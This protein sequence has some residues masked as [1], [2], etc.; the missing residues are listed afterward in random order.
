[1]TVKQGPQDCGCTRIAVRVSLTAVGWIIT[2]VAAALSVGDN[3]WRRNTELP[4][5][6]ERVSRRAPDLFPMNR[7]LA[8]RGVILV[9]VLWIVMILSVAS[10]SL[11]TA[12]RTQLS[13]T[14]NTFDAQR[15]FFMAQG[16][17]EVMFHQMVQ[18]QNL[19]ADSRIEQE[20]TV[21]VFPME[22]GEVRAHFETGRSHININL[23]SAA[24]LASTGRS[25][26]NINLA[27]A[28]LL[29][30]MMDSLGVDRASRNQ[31]VDSILD[32]RDADDI[33]N[34]VWRGIVGLRPGRGTS[35]AGKR[36]V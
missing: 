1:M 20:G 30:S 18:N 21:F 27:S 5:A 25:H 7:N 19:F 29:A 33:P 32:W 34:L 36:P 24:L 16:A 8:S 4:R 3:R 28:A 6:L 14:G 26:I 2:C 15:A 10:L 11:A 22:T 17:A 13:A 23:A 31:L 12:V 9:S 35:A